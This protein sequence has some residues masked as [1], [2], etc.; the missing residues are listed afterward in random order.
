MTSYKVNIE[1]SIEDIPDLN[2]H[3]SM[4]KSQIKYAIENNRI[5]EERKI[6]YEGIDSFHEITITKENDDE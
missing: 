2:L 4:A 6:R 3:M 1:M 5:G